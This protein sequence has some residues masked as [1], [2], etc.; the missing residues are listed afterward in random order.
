M[1]VDVMGKNSNSVSKF[2]PLF[3]FRHNFKQDDNQINIYKCFD[4][5]QIDT[6]YYISEKSYK[7][8]K[9]STI[10]MFF[11]FPSV[12]YHYLKRH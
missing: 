4:N 6:F 11:L 8:I 7:K 12:F 2:L 9:E 1:V 10:N 5:K 3:I